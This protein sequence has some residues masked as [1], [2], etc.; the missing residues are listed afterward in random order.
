MNKEVMLPL[1]SGNVDRAFAFILAG[2]G[3][4]RGGLQYD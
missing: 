1:D 4:W 3:S 2:N